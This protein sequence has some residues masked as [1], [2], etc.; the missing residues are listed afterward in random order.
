MTIVATITSDTGTVFS[1][2][3]F[4]TPDGR[5]PDWPVTVEEELTANG[6]DGRRFRDVSQRFPDFT[7]STLETVATYTGAVTR[8]RYYD[9]IVGTIVKLTITNLGGTASYTYDR[10]HV[11]AAVPRAVPGAVAGSATPSNAA[12]IE[13]AL[14]LVLLDV[15]SG[16]NP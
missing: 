2:D 6:V 7:V 4:L 16:S 14:S 10:V 12:H 11:R 9:R 8:C 15:V 1:F 5:V 13:A 3:K